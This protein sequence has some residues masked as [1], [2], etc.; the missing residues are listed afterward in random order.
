ML[1]GNNSAI[2]HGDV[3]ASIASEIDDIFGQWI[4]LPSSMNITADFQSRNAHG[5]WRSD[6]CFIRPP[7]QPRCM[8]AW[9]LL[10]HGLLAWLCLILRHRWLKRLLGWLCGK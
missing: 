5:D 1:V 10:L 2:A 4:G 8:I 6:L 9:I 3:I 7:Y